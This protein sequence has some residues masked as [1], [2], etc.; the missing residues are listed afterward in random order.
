MSK[1]GLLGAAS[2]VEPTNNKDTLEHNSNKNG[3]N[4]DIVSDMKIDES[5]AQNNDNSVSSLKESAPKFLPFKKWKKETESTFKNKKKEAPYEHE[6]VSFSKWKGKSEDKYEGIKKITESAFPEILLK[7]SFEDAETL[8]ELLVD[9]SVEM[10][11]LESDQIE[12]NKDYSF[13]ALAQDIKSDIQ[14]NEDE[15]KTTKAKED[16]L[17]ID[18]RKKRKYDLQKTLLWRKRKSTIADVLT[19]LLCF[20]GIFICLTLFYD[21]FNRSFTKMN[22]EPIGTITFKYKSAQRKLTDRVLWDRVQQN[23]PIYDG[24]I[25]RTADLSEATIT[26]LDGN[27]INLYEQSLVQVHYDETGAS[28]DF[29][30]GGIAIDTAST[31]EGL[32]LTSSGSVVVLEADSAL[33]A[34]LD[35]NIVNG[36]VEEG[37]TAPIILQVTEGSAIFTEPEQLQGTTVSQ[38]ST[39]ALSSAGELLEAPLVSVFSPALNAKYLRVGAESVPV[40][41]TW[42]VPPESAEA[43]TFELSRDEDFLQIEQRQDV[44]NIN[45]LNLDLTDGQWY[46]RIYTG[47]PE[48]G[49][50]GKFRVLEASLPNTI[51]P[52]L[53][54]EY[55]YT[56]KAPS[57]RFQW[58]EDVYASEWLF[59]VSDNEQMTNPHVSLVTTQTTTVINTLEEGSWYWQVTPVYPKGVFPDS[60]VGDIRSPVSVFSVHKNQQSN[61]VELIL[62]Q[63]DEFLD[64]SANQHFSWKY[65]DDAAFYTISISKNRNMRFPTLQKDI[66]Q[67][68]FIASDEDTR[69]QEGIWYWTVTKT[70]EYGNESPVSEVRSFLAL[71]GKFVHNTVFPSNNDILFE[72]DFGETIFTWENN[73]PYDTYFQIAQDEEFKNIVLDELVKENS[74]SDLELDVGKWFWRIVS[75]DDELQREY[76]TRAKAFYID[77]SIGIVDL[78][79]PSVGSVVIVGPRAQ[80]SF[81]WKE[82]EHAQHY[83]MRLFEKN[84]LQTPV[85]ENVMIENTR[86]AV[87]MYD[88]PKGEYVCAIQAVRTNNPSQTVQK[89]IVKEY[90]FSTRTINLIALTSPQDGY[91]IDGVTALTN[92]ISVRWSSSENVGEAQFLLSSSETALNA[93]ASGRATN[94][95]RSQILVTTDNPPNSINLPALRS[96]RWYWTIIGETPEGHSIT[97]ARPSSIVVAP[98][99]N[100]PMPSA[101]EPAHRESFGVAYFSNNSFID[102]SWERVVGAET[103]IFILKDDNNEVLVEEILSTNSYHFESLSLLDRGFFT[104]SVEAQSTLPGDIKRQG[105]VRTSSFVIDLPEIISPQD[106]TTGDLYGL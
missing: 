82:V 32:S 47:N 55:G 104:W 69:I 5:M 42:S 16:L 20:A 94:A 100:M 90:A 79:S 8:E 21:S 72:D 34:S 11:S 1:K 10:L 46:W 75:K 40:V 9:E 39:V 7:E 97:P 14:K 48:E 103:Y 53:N 12:I 17:K 102:F 84:D 41:V 45:T 66:T 57:I 36:Q 4:D 29:S 52:S 80:V 27:V 71:Q 74:I 23:T 83:E 54:E 13:S 22:E 51:V 64:A 99:E 56:T 50:T 81:S 62:P 76:T 61:P 37:S 93:V 2:T 44:S 77:Y 24:D 78:V 6:L 60:S 73:L 86:L 25:I 89:S 88:M 3:L 33:I 68:Y 43:Y 59:E 85:Y 91:V 63:N 87:N 67:N 35:A 92:P 26:F 19:V 96:G 106:K 105:E 28:V 95:Q 65:N 38:G 18:S 101:V 30:A 58:A 31:G 49:N 70:D 15:I 98:I